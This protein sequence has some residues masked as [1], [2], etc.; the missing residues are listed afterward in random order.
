[1][2]HPCNYNSA[3]LRAHLERGTNDEEW[4]AKARL[5][6]NDRANGKPFPPERDEYDSRDDYMRR[7]WEQNMADQFQQERD[8]Y[9]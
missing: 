3:T 6:L 2:Y 8:F 9:R 4:N 5:E 1:M 7:N